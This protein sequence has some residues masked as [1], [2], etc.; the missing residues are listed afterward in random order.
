M[1]MSGWFSDISNNV[2]GRK[3]GTKEWATKSVIL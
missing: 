1:I 2:K 3:N